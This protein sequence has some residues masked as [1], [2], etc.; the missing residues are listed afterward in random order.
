MKLINLDDLIAKADELQ[1]LPESATKLVTLINSGEAEL[2]EITKI[3]SVDPAMTMKILRSA[4]SA[5]SG[6]AMEISTVAEAVGR[7]GTQRIL[8][9][10]VASHARGMMRTEITAY[11]LNEG[12]LWRH[13]V[14]AMVAAETSVRFCKS[15]IVPASYTAALLHDI[16]KLVMARFLDEGIQEL[17]KQARDEGG[18]SPLDA[19]ARVLQVHHGELGGLIVQHWKLPENI[20]KAVTYHHNPEQ[21][22]D[23]ICDA[24][25]LADDVSKQVD[26]A[27]DDKKVESDLDSE[28]AERLGFDKKDFNELCTASRTAFD[29]I[30]GLFGTS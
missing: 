27:L 17:L 19:E 11:G 21:G 14:S 24:V 26:A 3:I 25:H 8:S 5:F 29:K 4:N 2:E 28:A 23:L 15:P 16:G 18:M 30:S 9:L 6:S 22:E 12:A 7:L 13:S 20:V 1:P 10:A